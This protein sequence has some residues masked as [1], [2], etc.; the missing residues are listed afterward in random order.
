MHQLCCLELQNM[1]FIGGCTL[2]PTLE[3][4]SRGDP[5]LLLFFVMLAHMGMGECAMD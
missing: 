1:I 2:F 5:L 3:P 4:P